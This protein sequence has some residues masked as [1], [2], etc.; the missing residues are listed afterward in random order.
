MVASA[1]SREVNGRASD[2]NC[3][4]RVGFATWGPKVPLVALSH[5]VL[6]DRDEVRHHDHGADDPGGEG[7]EE[8]QESRAVM[9][10]M[11]T[12]PTKTNDA[13]MPKST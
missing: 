3:L 6:V 11:I 12:L 2:S 9:R 4:T 5:P 1:G 13:A 8:H 7:Y 10:W